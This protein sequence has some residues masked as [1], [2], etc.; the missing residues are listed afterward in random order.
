VNQKD[1]K[2]LRRRERNIEKRLARDN[3]PDHDGPVMAA[4]NIH[5][6]MGEKT[7][8]IGCGGIGAFHTLCQKTG[9]P[10]TINRKVNVFKRHLPYHRDVLG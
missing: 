3:Y 7:R 2:I 6:E 5:Y 10:H 9:L 4:S 1:N 8:A